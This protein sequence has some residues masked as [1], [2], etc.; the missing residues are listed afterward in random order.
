MPYI[1][2]KV[3][4]DGSHYI[5]IPHMPRKKCLKKG[6]KIK[7]QV[8]VMEELEEESTPFD[9]GVQMNM[10]DA[11]NKA[12]TIQ[13]GT[14]E[15]DPEPLSVT[16]VRGNIEVS[17][18]RKELFEALYKKYLFEPKSRRRQAVYAG[19]R[20]YFKS[21]SE[22]RLFVE[23]NFERKRKNLV[24]R[25]IRM[26]RKANLQDFNFFVTLTYND[27]LH[28][29]DSFRKKL[30][31]CLS[32]LS[33]RKVWKYIGVWER[34]PEKK[35]LHFHGV[36]DIPQGSM[37]GYFIQKEDYSFKRHRRQIT[38]QNTYFL[39]NYGRND[40]EKI[41]D[42]SRVGD[43]L[44]YIMKY[45]EK[46]EEKIVYSKGM[47]Q[48]FIS[49][50]MDEDIVCRVGIEDQKLLLFDDFSCWDEGE[51][52]GQVSRETITKMPKAN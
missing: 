50:I 16:A 6:V 1:K 9:G 18:P 21:D 17:P 31:N 10:F 4:S 13:K 26:T 11:E 43:A 15:G 34:S 3:Y 51:Y 24:A 7:R 29:E 35:R 49:D 27:A 20:P 36:F 12:Q 8:P 5:A 22:A 39:E 37:P 41:E 46:S 30:R 47:P 19:M 32:L 28:T 14:G 25:R 42:N 45:M 33:S 40:F 2:A 52:I 38:N 44:A 23:L 48:Y